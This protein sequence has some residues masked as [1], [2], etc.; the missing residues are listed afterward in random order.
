MSFHQFNNPKSMSPNSFDKLTVQE[1][2]LLYPSLLQNADRHIRAAILI[3]KTKEYGIA[4]AHLTIAAEEYISAL[5]IYLKGWGLPVS[6]IKSLLR[7]FDEQGEGYTVSPGVVVMGVFVRSLYQIFERTTTSILNLSLPSLRSLFDKNMNPLYLVQ[8]SNRYST[9]W[10]NAKILK[11]KGLYIQ[12]NVELH[13]PADIT[14]DHYAQSLE[15]VS[16]L[17]DNCLGVIAFTK[18]IP[19]KQRQQFFNWI[20]DY[21][22]PLVGRLDS[23]PFN[24]IF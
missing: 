11:D 2:H 15:I 16:E 20:K 10:A 18:K 17:K 21:F 6:Q 12:Y 13:T 23:F 8:Q 4:N 14:I 24:K 1:C 9:W 5:S 22:E 7:F 3:A 19:E